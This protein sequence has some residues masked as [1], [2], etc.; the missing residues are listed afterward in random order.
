MLGLLAWDDAEE[1]AEFEPVFRRYLAYMQGGRYVI[2]RRGAD[3][4]F[5][6]QV[7][8]D[9]MPRITQMIWAVLVADRR[10]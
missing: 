4:V 9:A 6:T 5:A 8:A 7:P 1:A 3:V 10:D 2:Q